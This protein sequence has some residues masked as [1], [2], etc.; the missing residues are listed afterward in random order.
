MYIRL[1]EKFDT[2]GSFD[3]SNVDTS[4]WVAIVGSQAASEEEN[5]ATYR[6]GYICGRKGKIVVTNL[7]V[8]IATHAARGALKAGGTVV[9]L[10]STPKSQQVY[11]T[12]SSE[13]ANDIMKN[14][15]ILHAFK[16]AAD[17]ASTPGLNQFQKRLIERDML[18]AWLCPVTV[19]VQDAPEITGMAKWAMTYAALFE[20]RTFRY[21]TQH[22]YTE[23]PPVEKCTPLRSTELTLP[24]FVAIA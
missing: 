21:D 15:C 23:S 17:F 4:S 6:L 22:Q 12:A 20:R 16:N 7:S 24:E 19:A 11:P 5:K 3:V 2:E 9:G 10:V 14:G 8:G 18:M 13:L 1:A